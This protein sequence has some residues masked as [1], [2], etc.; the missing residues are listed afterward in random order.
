MKSW[1][2]EQIIYF[3]LDALEEEHLG[4]KEFYKNLLKEK[5]GVEF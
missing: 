1:Y 5:F 2:Y 3:L 4:S